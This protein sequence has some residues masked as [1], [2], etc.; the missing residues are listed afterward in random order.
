MKLL[1]PIVS[2][3][4][5][6]CSKSIA[7]NSDTFAKECASRQVKGEFTVRG[8]DPAWFFMSRE[9]NQVALGKFWEKDWASI[10]TNKSDPTPHIVKFNDLLKAKGVKLV[11]VPIPAKAAIYPDKLASKF[12]V[13]DVLPLK[14]YYDELRQQGV[15]VLDIEPILRDH[16]AKTGGEGKDKL[17]CEQDAHF[18]PLT[19][20]IIA[21]R[22]KKIIE[23]EEW[24]KNQPKEAFKR[25]AKGTLTIKGDQVKSGGFT[26]VPKDEVLTLS[27]AGRDVG[28]KIEAVPAD[29]D[30]PVLLVGDS[31]T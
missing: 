23:K 22:V 16:R 31:H 3:L 12:T 6:L 19:T 21:A 24:Y 2:L 5:A 20:E 25:S 13:K 10:A 30:S 18:A 26:P 15:D 8:D 28:G 1:I 4:V 9:L 11:M 14:G 29:K 17:F 27:Y 7:Q